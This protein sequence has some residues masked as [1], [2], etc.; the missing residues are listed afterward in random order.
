MAWKDTCI[1]SHQQKAAQFWSSDSFMGNHPNRQ[2]I[3]YRIASIPS[4]WRYLKIRICNSPLFCRRGLIEG[5]FSYEAFANAYPHD[6]KHLRTLGVVGLGH[7]GTSWD[8][9]KTATKWSHHDIMIL[10]KHLSMKFGWFDSVR[11]NWRYFWSLQILF[12]VWFV[13]V[14]RKHWVCWQVTKVVWIG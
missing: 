8:P 13:W 12:A 4:L 14:P 3:G 2:R 5:L 11:R 10:K 9:V 6:R 7:L 1:L